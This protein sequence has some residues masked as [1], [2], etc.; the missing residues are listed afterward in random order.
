M[1]VLVYVSRYGICIS[2]SMRISSTTNKLNIFSSQTSDQKYL[3]GLLLLL[4]FLLFFP[5][6]HWL[7]CFE[8]KCNCV[9]CRRCHQMLVFRTYGSAKWLDITHSHQELKSIIFRYWMVTKKEWKKTWE[10][11]APV[12]QHFYYKLIGTSFSLSSY[13]YI[14]IMNVSDSFDLLFSIKLNKINTYWLS[15]QPIQS[16][17]ELLLAICFNISFYTDCSIH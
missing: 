7:S 4:L 17:I 9:K 16:K 15:Q 11:T 10:I 2:N 3:I 8:S 13:S 14:N 6:F 5:L 12:I 1:L